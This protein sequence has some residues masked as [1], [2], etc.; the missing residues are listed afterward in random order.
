MSRILTALLALLWI[1]CGKKDEGVPTAAQAPAQAPPAPAV[2]VQTG[3]YFRFAVPAGWKIQE[4]GQFAVVLAAPDLGA[5]TIMVGNSGVP[6]NYPPARFVQEKLTALQ[7]Q[8]LRIGRAVMARPLAGCTTGWEFDYAYTVNGE[9]CRGIAKCSAAP[10]YD[11]CTMV[12]TCAA[13]KEAQWGA[14]SAWLPQV[15]ES[16]SAQ[17]GGAFGAR[18]VLEQNL[19][20]SVDLGEQARQNREWS[21]KTWADVQRARTDSQDRN[22]AQ[23]R[24]NLGNVQPFTNPYDSAKIELP[25]TFTHYWVN[26]QGRIVGTNNP[27]ENPNSGSTEEWSRMAPARR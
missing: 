17:N 15:A 8:N 23:F 4:D 7:V 12:V 5:M 24:D 18:G 3:R 10:A 21:A 6:A 16:I 14:Y 1:G 22:N 27:A 11:T 13:A 9:A 26:R 20:N 25:G 19:R 2:G